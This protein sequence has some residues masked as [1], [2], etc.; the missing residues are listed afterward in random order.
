MTV[1]GPKWTRYQQSKLANCLFTFALRDKLEVRAPCLQVVHTLA[2][3]PEWVSRFRPQPRVDTLPLV[4]LRLS[5]QARGSRVKAL[6]AHPGAA[7]TQL[8][9]RRTNRT[10]FNTLKELQQGVV[11]LPGYP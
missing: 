9:V 8:Q 3:R 11:L 6:L 5:P 2:R 1:S 10:K 7:A 4:R